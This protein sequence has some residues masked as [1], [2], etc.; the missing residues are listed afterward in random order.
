MNEKSRTYS[1]EI[2]EKKYSSASSLWNH[3]KK[4][5]NDE[6][7]K[8]SL[9]PK[10]SEDLSHDAPQKSSLL[11]K[12]V[13]KSELLVQKS[14]VLSIDATSLEEA[15]E[16][17][18]CFK[19]FN[20]RQ[21]KW[22]HQKNCSIINKINIIEEKI[23]SMENKSNIITNINYNTSNI[24]NNTANITNNI[25]NILINKLGYE[26]VNVLTFE[27]IKTIFR[28][29]TNCLITLINSLNFNE[30][31]PENH[32]FCV[33]SLEGKYVKVY[34]SDKNQI[35]KKIKK[36]FYDEIFN[37]SIN[38]MY[39]LLQQVHNKVSKKKKDKLESMINNVKELLLIQNKH[40]TTY[41]NE[42][43]LLSYNNRNLVLDTWQKVAPNNLIEDEQSDSDDSDNSSKD[44]FYY[45]SDSD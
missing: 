5:H 26:D 19:K 29:Q 30:K 32:S 39:K 3:N 16:C 25:S 12:N 15:Y 24:T 4:F 9:L 36:N 8:S 44:S 35:E 33:T 40:K 7:Q 6:R 18:S 22:Y 45:C 41:N 17:L 11:S 10:K 43:N 38:T 27:E 23:N 21:A 34:N 14:E 13:K 1:C 2:C 28:A 42:L 31:M 20:T 37:S